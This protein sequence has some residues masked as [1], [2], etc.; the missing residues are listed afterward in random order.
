MTRRPR[1]PVFGWDIGGVNTK[2]ARLENG[3][4]AP[5]VR[6]VSAAFEIQRDPAGLVPT[7]GSLAAGLGRTDGCMHGVTM[8]AELSQAFRTKREGVEFVLD[9]VAAAFPADAVRVYTVEG[10]F[11]EPAEARSHPLA[12]AASNWMATASYV[13]R[14]VP[15]G[16][17]IDIGTTS[18]D[19]IPISGGRVAARG[20]TDPARL[21]SGELVYTGA[22]RTPAEALVSEVPL[23][24]GMAAVSAEWFATIGDAHL[25]APG[26]A[27]VLRRAAGPR[28]VRRS[29]DAGRGGDRSDRPRAGRGADRAGGRGRAPG[30]GGVSGRG[31][32]GGD[33]AGRFHRRGRGPPRRARRHQARRQPRRFGT[34]RPCCRGSVAAGRRARERPAVSSLGPL[35]VIKVGGGLSATPGALE[36]VCAALGAAGRRHR[37]LVVPGGGP[38]A[39]AVREFDRRQPLSPDAAHW[40]AILAMDQYAHVLADRIPGAVMVEEAGAVNGVLGEAGIAVLLPSRCL[41]AFSSSAFR[42]GTLP[43]SDG[44]VAGAASPPRRPA[45]PPSLSSD[46][47]NGVGR[48]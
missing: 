19:I 27:S 39:D 34:H 8:T 30:S 6:G 24:L 9:A 35:T 29:R 41:S 1:A 37:L 17:L 44:G 20:L 4:G 40:M 46:I 13:A 2:A 26:H 31:D 48:F 11:I 25:W 32:R 16:I 33:G 23:G 18:T 7:L 28:R 5:S 38:F 3:D 47:F 42:L 43:L 15:D 22:V 10:R 36:A 21:G 12:A 14:T 45:A